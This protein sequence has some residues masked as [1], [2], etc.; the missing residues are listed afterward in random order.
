MYPVKTKSYWAELT[1][2][3]QWYMGW[4]CEVVQARLRSAAKE[5]DD[6]R[7][8]SSDEHWGKCWGEKKMKL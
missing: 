5:I 6:E 2:G 1:P 8:R 4:R 3:D 7:K